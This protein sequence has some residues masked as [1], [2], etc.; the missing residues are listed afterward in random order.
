MATSGLPALPAELK[1]N[2]FKHILFNSPEDL[3]NTIKTCKS[4]HEAY[5][6]NRAYIVETI[7][8][9]LSPEQLAV[10]AAHYHAIV[11]PWKR[12]KVIS[13]PITQENGDYLEKVANFCEQHLSEQGTE[14]S[15]LRDQLT[16]PMAVHIRDMHTAILN[17]AAKIDRK[18]FNGRMLLWAITAYPKNGYP[19]FFD[20]PSPSPTELNAMLPKTLYTVDLLLLL[21]PKKLLNWR[22]LNGLGTDSELS[23]FWSCFAPWKSAQVEFL[24][25]AMSGLVSHTHSQSNDGWTP[26]ARACIMFMVLSG[27]KRLGSIVCDG[28]FSEDDKTLFRYCIEVSVRMP[29][30]RNQLNWVASPTHGFAVLGG[31]CRVIP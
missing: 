14:L 31:R 29:G 23:R 13:V 7:L 3:L 28:H 19:D 10:A 24:I 17:V 4:L 1:V 9:P 12:D 25:G 16:L 21:F 27:L 8:P 11:A 15:T 26:N 20:S 6:S 22:K 2:A 30:A 5:Q 18:S